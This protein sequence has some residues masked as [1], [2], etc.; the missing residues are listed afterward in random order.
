MPAQHY[1]FVFLAGAGQFAGHRE[2]ILVVVQKLVLNV[3]LQ[4]HRNLLVEEPRDAVVLL[5][6]QRYR[7]RRHR[8]LGILRSSGCAEHDAAGGPIT[9]RQC[10]QHALVGQELVHLVAKLLARLARF[11]T[12]GLPRGRPA[13]ARRL[14]GNERN[15]IGKGRTRRRIGRQHLRRQFGVGEALQRRLG[16]RGQRRGILQQHDLAL[17]LPFELVEIRIGPE[18]GQYRLSRNRTVRAR[19]P[20]PRETVQRRILRFL[21]APAE[22]DASP[23]APEGSPLLHTGISQPPLGHAAD[24]PFGGCFQTRRARQPGTVHVGQVKGVFH[25]LGILEFLSLDAIDGVQIHLLFSQQE[26]SKQQQPRMFHDAD[27][28][29]TSSGS[30]A[31]APRGLKPALHTMQPAGL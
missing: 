27:E 16:F 18:D 15:R 13:R 5:H 30:G 28:I 12:E 10:H 19:R 20:G 4:G 31:K 11:R 1:Q 9:R 23:A 24:C 29:I 8:L 22:V 26:R 2:R 25:H 17:E 14:S 6:F 7:W 3:E 21:Q